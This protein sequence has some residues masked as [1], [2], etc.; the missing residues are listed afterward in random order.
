MT[1]LFTIYLSGR[2]Y[3]NRWYLFG[4]LNVGNFPNATPRLGWLPFTVYRH[5]FRQSDPDRHLHN[6][7]WWALSWITDGKYTEE[8]KQ[9]FRKRGRW[10]FR[11]LS[12]GYYHRVIL[13]TPTVTTLFIAGPNVS[14][15]GYHIPWREYRG[16]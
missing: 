8:T 4:R 16:R 15:W 2:P 14:N 3:L 11:I 10:S 7:P 13:D 6:H 1:N 9:G 12:P 5:E